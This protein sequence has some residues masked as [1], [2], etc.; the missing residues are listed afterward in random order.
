MAIQWGATV[1]GF[2]VGLDLSGSTLIAY[3]GS[4]AY[5]QN[6]SSTMVRSGAWSGSTAFSFYSA[7]AATVVKEIYRATVSASGTYSVSISFYGGTVSASRS[8]QLGSK[9]G[10]PS[11]FAITRTGATTATLSFTKGSGA[12]S[13]Q[14]TASKNGTTWY[15]LANPT[16][17]SQDVSGLVVDS[18]WRF[19]AYSKNAAGNSAVIGPYIMY[20]TPKTP[21]TPTLA[22]GRKVAWTLPAKYK[23]GVQLAY[24]D[25]TSG[26]GTTVELG[27]VTSWTDPQAQPP[28]RQYRVRSWAGPSL[29]EERTY[30]DWSGWSATAMG[31]TYKAPQI[32][33]LTARRCDAAGQLTELGRYLKVTSSGTVSK[34]PGV[35]GA[36]TNK[37]TRKVQWRQVGTKTW[38]ST[39]VL[40]AGAP[41]NWT[42]VSATVG[43]NAIAETSAWQV[44]Y[45][46][47]DTYTTTPVVQQVTVPVSQVALS[48]AD[49]GVG[50]GKI[51]E[52]GALD[53][54]GDAH[55]SG[56]LHVG[57][58]DMIAVTGS[59]TLT[60]SSGQYHAFATLTFS[61]PFATAP[62][63]TV[64][65]TK[66][67]PSDWYPTI[68][69]ITATT[70]R[71]GIVST[72]STNATSQLSFPVN[73][74]AVGK[75]G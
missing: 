63:V 49:R 39:T 31:V 24:R 33:A 54:Q 9:P 8:V 61:K 21:T 53:V 60:V 72:T 17:S 29:D 26:N 74:I 42:N 58:P 75:P 15:N 27:A 59:T 69:G 57:D 30:S 48:L 5:G 4:V 51:W 43:G 11:N 44:R 45:T 34:V 18:R 1:S 55:I 22:S 52:R 70:V 67:D 65:R 35:G 28:T 14:I 41:D 10:A 73:Y 32:T 25:T 6:F 37:V 36:E 66:W 20:T 47:T 62:A 2:R 23:M 68:S 13:T 50:V 19:S 40:N 7:Y 71:V 3:A 56:K 16:G 64:T 38:S 12:T 46:A